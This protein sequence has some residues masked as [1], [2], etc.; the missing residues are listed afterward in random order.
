M[1]KY[2]LFASMLG[3]IFPTKEDAEKFRHQCKEIDQ[4]KTVDLVHN[5]YKSVLERL[6]AKYKKEKIKVVFLN[7]TAAKWQYQSLYDELSSNE[8]FEVQILITVMDYY[9]KAKMQKFVDYKEDARKN[10]AFF[11]SNNMNVDYAFDLEKEKPIDLRN[12]NPDIIVY[13]QPWGLF[14]IHNIQETSKFAINCYSSY[15]AA[16]T[17]SKNEYGSLFYKLLYRYFIDNEYTK[18]ILNEHG[19]PEESIIT[20]GHPKLDNYIRPLKEDQTYWKTTGKKRIIIAPHFSFYS[21][22]ILHAGTFDRNHKFLL[23]YAQ[24]HTEYEFIFK[25]HP[26]LKEDIVKHNLMSQE[27]CDEYYNK[28]ATLPNTQ[29]KE[30]GNYI[31]MFRT[32][33]LLITDCNSFL[34][35]YLPTEKPVIHIINEKFA[36]HNAFGRKI[37]S[38]YYEVTE[39][40]EIELCL[41]QLLE[42]ENDPLKE[43]RQNLL[44]SGIHPKE[45]YAKF[46]V[47]HIIDSIK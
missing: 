12:F 38:G 1:S 9:T 46:V 18:W 33:D 41:K 13:E 26:R 27:E 8:D 42:D 22:A 32:S 19:A 35:E 23:D 6:K 4:R 3:W 20:S 47:K 2:Y 21:G 43:Y 36:G 29:L 44:N 16:I 5:R 7:D 10:Y 11:K 30:S 45:G 37:T 24:K 15:G 31:D 25:P 39:N 34:Y 14:D 40:E 28:W 17:S